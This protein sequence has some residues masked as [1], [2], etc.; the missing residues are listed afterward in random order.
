MVSGTCFSAL[1]F[2][3]AVPVCI[4]HVTV[5]LNKEYV[6]VRRNSNTVMHKV[7]YFGNIYLGMPELQRFTM[8]FD[9]GSA[10]LFVPDEACDKPGC[11]AHRRYSAKASKTAVQLD[12]NGNVATG[13]KVEDPDEVEIEYGTGDIAG[14]FFREIVCVDPTAVNSFVTNSLKDNL[15]SLNDGTLAQEAA[16]AKGAI[17]GCTQMRVITATHMSTEPFGS[18]KFDGVLGLGLDSLAIEP[19]YSFLR[20]FLSQHHEL[21]SMFGLFMTRNDTY[22]SEVHFGG[23]DTQRFSGELDYSEVLDPEDGHWKIGLKRVFVAG[24]PIEL[25]E[26]GDCEAV[27]D[28]GTSLLGVPKGIVDHVNWL[29]ARAVPDNPEVMDCSDFPGPSIV[30]DMGTFN[31]T[32]DA[33]DVTRPAGIRI[34]N[35]QTGQEQ[36]ACRAQLLPIPDREPLGPKSWILGEPIFRRYYTAFDW[37]H[38]RIGFAPSVQPTEPPEVPV[39]EVIGAPIKEPVPPTVVFI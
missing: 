38:Q 31:L 30:F 17:P 2:A 9:T 39:H 10:H 27:V 35:N 7:A 13:K 33:P 34:I 5:P 19:E 21:Q 23:V 12:H 29:L 4:S 15:T 28:S 22:A 36:F 11:T 18:F 1:I 8:V 6:H 26:A 14:H 16:L 20:Q 25:C 3:L 32:L 24:K 37:K